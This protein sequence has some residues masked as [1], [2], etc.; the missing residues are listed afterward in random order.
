MTAIINGD[1]VDALGQFDSESV[2]L[3]VADPPYNIGVDYGNGKKADRRQDYDVWCE[4]WINLCY[5]VLK[6][7]GSIWVISGQEHGADI[8][9]ALQHCGFNVRNRITWHESFGVYCHNKFGRTS[10]PIYYATKSK[11]GFT[12]NREA[13]MV[14]SLRAS[15]YKDR[16]AQ[17]NGLKIMGDVWQI[18]RVCGTFSERIKG[19]PTQLPVELVSRIVAVSSSPGDT[20]L[21][22][23]AGSGTTLVAAVGMGRNA[24]GIELNKSYCAAAE[25]RLRAM[26]NAAS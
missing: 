10:R 12:F 11:R 19:F 13:V 9:H 21:D 4:T 7:S 22:P 14:P 26:S 15:K 24:V 17:A 25:R 8:D 20:I 3:I 5:L 18:P 2:D 1:C 6:P 23:F 16:R